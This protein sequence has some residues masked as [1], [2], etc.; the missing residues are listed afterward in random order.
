MAFGQSALRQLER[1]YGSEPERVEAAIRSLLEDDEQLRW[2]L[3]VSAYQE[4]EINLG[5]AAELLGCL[6]IE[7]RG[8]FRELGIPLRVGPADLAEAH[9]EVEGLRAWFGQDSNG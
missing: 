7:L 9:A 1:L 8:R 6:E 4:G 3:V 2:M 5:K